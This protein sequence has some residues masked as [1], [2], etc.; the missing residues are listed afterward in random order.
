MLTANTTEDA[1][2]D[3]ADVMAKD[4]TMLRLTADGSARRREF[5]TTG[6][7]E[8]V[9]REMNDHA[10]S[11]SPAA[12]EKTIAKGQQNRLSAD[13]VQLSKPRIVFMILVTTWATALIGA[14]GWVAGP[15]LVWL[16]L[17]TAGVAASAGAANQIW[18]R[19]I[20]RNMTRTATRPLPAERMGL[21]TALAFATVTGL[22]G[23][24]LLAW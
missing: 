12:S 6:D 7:T 9:C 13:L 3:I 8:T 23:S 1:V 21:S 10:A 5:E 19:R 20:D 16:L 4:A 15:E 18:E 2:S 24:W 11:V 22:G 14:G 17:G